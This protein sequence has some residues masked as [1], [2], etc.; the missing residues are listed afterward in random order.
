[1]LFHCA[2]HSVNDVRRNSRC[3]LFVCLYNHADDIEFYCYMSAA[4]TVYQQNSGNAIYSYQVQYMHVHVMAPEQRL[5]RLR[6]VG[7]QS[8]S[9]RL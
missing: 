2:G 1:M 9:L 8:E 4:T 3:F 5:R 6:H 7:A